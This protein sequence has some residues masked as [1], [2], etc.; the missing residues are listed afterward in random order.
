MRSNNDSKDKKINARKGVSADRIKAG[1]GLARLPRWQ[2]FSGVLCLNSWVSLV[3]CR[4]I[5]HAVPQ[6]DRCSVSGKQ[7][8]TEMSSLLGHLSALLSISCWPTSKQTT[9]TRGPTLLVISP[10]LCLSPQGNEIQ[11]TPE[12]M[13]HYFLFLFRPS[14]YVYMY[15]EKQPFYIKHK[16]WKF[17]VK[18]SLQR[19]S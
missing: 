8:G 10:I 5:G 13:F 17:L 6:A 19:S 1:G 7:S 16:E 12:Q 4:L 14:M 18:T 3:V 15:V 9:S 11:V 2:L